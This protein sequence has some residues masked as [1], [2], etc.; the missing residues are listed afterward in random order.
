MSASAPRFNRRAP[1]CRKGRLNV[2]RS[3]GW[4][5]L[6]TSLAAV[7]WAQKPSTD[8]AEM[9]LE[10]L[11]DIEVTSVSKREQ[12]LAKVAA[13]KSELLLGRESCP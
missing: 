10:K 4:V 9:S 12:K 7:A 11:M 5:L 1:A 3:A 13:A 2:G 8:L 6:L